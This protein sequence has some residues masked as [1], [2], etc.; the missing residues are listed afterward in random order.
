M[1]LEE[2]L[3]V[4]VSA[5]YG[6]ILVLIGKVDYDNRGKEY[7]AL[8]KK[9]VEGRLTVPP[10][11][12]YDHTNAD[13]I[14]RL[15]LA[16]IGGLLLLVIQFLSVLQFSVI[17][18]VVFFLVGTIPIV[19][20]QLILWGI[21]RLSNKDHEAPAEDVSQLPLW[22][23]KR[24]ANRRTR[25]IREIFSGAVSASLL[26]F[27]LTSEFEGIFGF[28]PLVIG[29]GIMLVISLLRVEED[30]TLSEEEIEDSVVD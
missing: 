20:I 27:V 19:V 14:I 5:I 24:L 11:W 7:D 28:V 3:A 23:Q 16:A 18:P 13:Q 6:I 12:W 2:I 9:P 22:A 21:V 4:I 8:R 15:R 10:S 17:D 1:T 26:L 30:V 25:K 29:F